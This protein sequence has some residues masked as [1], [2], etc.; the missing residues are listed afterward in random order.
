MDFKTIK[1]LTRVVLGRKKKLGTTS[2]KIGEEIAQRDE[3]GR[4]GLHNKRYSV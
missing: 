3:C 4:G 1:I 2:K